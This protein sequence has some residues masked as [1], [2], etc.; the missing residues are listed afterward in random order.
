MNYKETD[1]QLPADTYK[2]DSESRTL[3]RIVSVFKEV[4]I[5]GSKSA[6]W[7]GL[8]TGHQRLMCATRA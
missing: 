3:E 8:L 4:R 5:S 1:W 6:E 2:A 7:R